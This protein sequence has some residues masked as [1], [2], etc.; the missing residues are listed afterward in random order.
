MDSQDRQDKSQASYVSALS[1]PVHA[2]YPC[3]RSSL[4][5]KWPGHAAV[6]YTC[7]PTAPAAETLPRLHGCCKVP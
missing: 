2:V 3:L 1:Y 7:A 4:R 5:V 6:G